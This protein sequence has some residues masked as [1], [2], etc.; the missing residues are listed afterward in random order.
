MN[1][2][3]KWKRLL[4]EMYELYILPEEVPKYVPLKLPSLLEEAR[5]EWLAAQQY[6]NAVTD[7]ELIDYAAYRLKAAERRYSYLLK[8][9]RAEHDLLH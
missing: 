4:T 3:T 7:K 5:Q 8:Q 9:V 2:L 6:C 1:L